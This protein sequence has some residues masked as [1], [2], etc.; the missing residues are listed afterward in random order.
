MPVVERILNTISELVFGP[1]T[2]PST[3]EL[4]KRVLADD[5]PAAPRRM[6]DET[7]LSH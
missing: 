6:S 4:M 2:E 3:N 1:A 7:D 5:P